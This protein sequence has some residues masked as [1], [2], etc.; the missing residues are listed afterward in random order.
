MQGLASLVQAP[1]QAPQGPVPGMLPQQGA[2]TPGA[3]TSSLKTM[4]LE[5][6]RALYQNPQPGSPPLWAV[7][8]ALAEKQKEAQAMM[9]AQGQSAMAQ[10]AQMQQQPPIAAQVVQAAEQMEPQGYAGGGAVAFQEGGIASAS[11]A[12]YQLARKYGIDLSPYDAPSVREE[13]IRR[14]RAMAD[15]EQQRQSF[16]EIPT[17]A[18]VA[19]DA[20]LQQ[21][22]ADPTRGRDVT[23]RAPTAL[24]TGTRFAG[25]RPAGGQRQA[26]RPT[27][28]MGVG[29]LMSPT[30][31]TG[32]PAPDALSNIESEGLA[33]IKALQDV[34]RQQGT[35][36]PRLAELR[37]AAYKS[38]QDIAAR[39]ERDRQAALEAAQSQYGDISDL[40]IGAAGGAKGKT[41][42]EVLSGAVGGAGAART[43]KR[44]EFQ[45]AQ[46]SARQEQN[47]IDQLN[48]ALADKRVADMTGDV[49]QRRQADIKVAEAQ[50][51]VT[52]LRSG[53]QKERAA[54]ADRAEQREI[55]RRTAGAQERTAEAAMIGAKTRA[56]GAEGR[57][58][59]TPYQLAQLRDK[60]RDNLKD[61]LPMIIREAKRKAQAAG[62]P[63]DPQAAEDV[64]IKREMERL[65]PGLSGE[66][67]AP[68][69]AAGATMP[70]G[71]WGKAQVVTP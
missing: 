51:K 53:I 3:M 17:E 18:S 71:N 57:G 38:S 44:A 43:A 55:Q 9:A 58:A 34:I 29:A 52:D 14:A 68:A 32:T 25:P 8:S 66:K 22:Y 1:G 7:I 70:P 50:L 10:N 41:F 23:Q 40:I 39:R 42:G 36:D 12:D 35:V 4:P 64:A 67:P 47:A 2:P 21:A 15:F 11:S 61:T 13:K 19:K 24:P 62:M 60:A 45:K 65:M 48:Q 28:N 26:Q 31:V 56:A 30:E 20:V 59:I 46:E 16:G 6:L 33:G 54:E 49:N 37:E 69:S 5:Q 27:T 63:F